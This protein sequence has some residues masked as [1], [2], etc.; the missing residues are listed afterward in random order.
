MCLGMAA[1]CALLAG[2]KTKSVIVALMTFSG[3]VTIVMAEVW[4]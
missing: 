2:V 1:C 3:L 4:P